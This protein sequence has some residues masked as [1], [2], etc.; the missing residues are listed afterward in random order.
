MAYDPTLD[1]FIPDRTPAQERA[2]L[3]DEVDAI[4]DT[5][6]HLYA[7]IPPALPRTPA[8]AVALGEVV[9]ALLKLKREFL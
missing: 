2:E 3:V 7:S 6:G 8:Q 9:A 4:L 5:V 1:A